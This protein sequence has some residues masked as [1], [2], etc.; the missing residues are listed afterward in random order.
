MDITRIQDDLYFLGDNDEKLTAFDNMYLLPDGMSFNSYLLKDEK[1]VLF[2]TIERPNVLNNSAEL[3]VWRLNKNPAKPYSSGFYAPDS[4]LHEEFIKKLENVLNG[5]KL[6]YVIV[7]HAEPDHTGALGELIS[8]HPETK[9][10]TTAMGRNFLKAFQPQIPDSQYLVVLPNKD[11][12]TGKHTLTFIPAPLVHWPEVFFVYDKTNG[13]LFS[14]D[15]FGKFGAIEAVFADENHLDDFF[16]SEMR[17]YYAN[18]V[19]KFGS[20]VQRAFTAVSKL[21][22]KMILPLHGPVWRKDFSTILDLYNKMSSYT[23]LDEKGVMV[24]IGTVYGHTGTAASHFARYFPEARFYDIAKINESYL[25]SEAFRS[26]VIIL[27]GITHEGEMFPPMEALITR[28]KHIGIR[29]RI[30]AVMENGTW[31]PAAGKKMLLALKEIPGNEVIDDIIT[32]KGTFNP[33]QEKDIE[34]VSDEIKELMK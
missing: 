13:N 28:L 18:I 22:I 31:A 11:F 6:D 21:D 1:N 20:S 34:R 4:H 14:A 15:A 33:E 7:Q 29:N 16:Y 12:V 2:E 27:A 9:I 24:G 30:F 8:L 23:P 19:G 5:E 25:I 32:V 10:V 17:R 3:S 26:K